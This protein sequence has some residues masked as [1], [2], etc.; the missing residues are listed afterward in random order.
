MKLLAQSLGVK[1]IAQT[2][3]SAIFIQSKKFELDALQINR[4]ETRDFDGSL[5]RSSGNLP[6]D[7]H[8]IIKSMRNTDSPIASILRGVNF[9][10]SLRER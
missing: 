9:R 3:H 1:S 2:S 4:I 7:L 6:K 8:L 5:S 10:V